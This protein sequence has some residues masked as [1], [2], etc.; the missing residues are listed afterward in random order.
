MK[1][2]SGENWIVSKNGYE[3]LRVGK[4]IS[5]LVIGFIIPVLLIT[6]FPLG[7]V[8]AGERGVQL[9]FSAVT[10]KVFEEGLYFRIPFVQQVK[11]MDVKVQKEQVEA[12]AASKDL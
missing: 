11:I 8:G 1:Y 7:T 2:F 6:Q 4:V 3:K 10:G 5:H 12:S 9:Q